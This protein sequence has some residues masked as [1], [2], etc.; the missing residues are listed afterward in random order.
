MSSLRCHYSLTEV[1]DLASVPSLTMKRKSTVLI[2]HK[3]TPYK[4][5]AEID[6]GEHFARK[7]AK[8]LLIENSDNFGYVI[9]DCHISA[10]G[11]V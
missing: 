8:S 10:P 3:P 9:A 2:F 11:V 4:L 1:I 5:A 7:H 6:L